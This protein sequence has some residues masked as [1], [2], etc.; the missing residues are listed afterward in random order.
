MSESQQ[1]DDK[2][3]WRH[4]GVRVIKGDQLDPNTPQSPGMH[5]EA[6]IN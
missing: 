1:I 5:R 2:P 4:H 6:A 3:D